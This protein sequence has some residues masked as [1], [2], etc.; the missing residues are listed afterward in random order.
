MMPK[1]SLLIC[2]DLDRTL[3]PN[4]AEP[5]SP[6]ARDY[7]RQLAALPTITLAYVS[8]RDQTLVRE[9]IHTYD[10][11]LPDFVLG[12][13]GAT[14]YTCEQ[15]DWQAWDAWANHIAPDWIGHSRAALAALLQDFPMLKLQEASKQNTYK[16]SYYLDLALNHQRVMDEVQMHL[17]THGI[18]ASLIWS[19][20]EPANIGLLDILPARA[21][22]RHAIEFLMAQQGFS[23]QQTVFSGDSGNDLPV[24]VSPIPA[25]LV[26][27]ASAELKREALQMSRLSGVADALY[28]AQGSWAG[29]NG[30]YAAGILEGIAHY[31]PEILAPLELSP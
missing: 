26:N 14:I 4:G 18:R 25:V 28:L 11:P 27:N 3:I 2:T 23:L 29:M 20:D 10:L 12:D 13:V 21:S 1:Q 22:K 19:I 30:H 15:W 5:E 8:G 17:S 24:L 16:L 9:A 6:R 7:F 31:H